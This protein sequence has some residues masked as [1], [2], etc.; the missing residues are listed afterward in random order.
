[1]PPFSLCTRLIGLALVSG[2][3]LPV[4]LV[5]TT[6]V[7]A[8][9]MPAAPMGQASAPPKRQLTSAQVEASARAA[10][11]SILKTLQSARGLALYRLFSPNLQQMTSP[12]LVQQRL[13]GMPTV[14]SW[15]I[16]AVE[17]GLDS[18]TVTAQ[19][20][21][22]AGNRRLLLVIDAAGLLEGYHLDAADQPAE[23]VA[24]KFVEALGMGRY[25]SARALLSPNLQEE[26][27]AAKLQLK[28]QRLQRLTGDFV[29]IKQVL[30]AESTVD[31]KLVLVTTRFS[32]LT[33]SLFVILDANNKIVGV[34]FPNAANGPAGAR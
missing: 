26:I 18:N 17:P 20:Q 4:G 25:V 24:R 16:G 12:A 11:E 3:A 34:D 23:A 21:T 8:Q 7:R 31:S 33:D 32:R 27:P 29:A 2:A 19:L 28:W 30:K 6:A 15:S 22:A 13:S 9:A 14:K 1:M 5:G 10:A